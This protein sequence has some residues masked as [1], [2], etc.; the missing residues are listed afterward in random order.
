MADWVKPEVTWLIRTS[1]EC[2]AGPQNR[3]TQNSPTWGLQSIQHQ[4]DT[5]ASSQALPD[6]LP[7]KNKNGSAWY[8]LI[9]YWTWL[10]M[11]WGVV[12]TH[13]TT[14]QKLLYSAKKGVSLSVL[15]SMS[16]PA[17]D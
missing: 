1:V 8:I 5:L 10:G 3:I 2:H 4:Y 7:N 14:P 15:T 9:T 6:P 16:W 11:V 12:W 17:G 13:S